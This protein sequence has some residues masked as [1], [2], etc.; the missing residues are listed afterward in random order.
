MA[1]I[2]TD[3]LVFDYFYDALSSDVNL[4]KKG[5]TDANLMF[6][7]TATSTFDCVY[8]YSI[9]TSTSDGALSSAAT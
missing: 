6:T 8:F 5:R 9:Y 3:T 1:T 4:N 7:T 2:T